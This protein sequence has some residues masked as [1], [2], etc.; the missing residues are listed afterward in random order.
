M[1]NEPTKTTQ[2]IIWVF[3]K[4]GI[5]GLVI[6]IY[7]IVHLYLAIRAIFLKGII[8]IPFKKLQQDETNIKFGAI[9]VI[10]IPLFVEIIKLMTWVQ[11]PLPIYFSV[12]WIIVAEIFYSVIV[13]EL[14]LRFKF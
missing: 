2:F 7:P 10:T 8:Y 12:I 9:S 6:I 3:K 1:K 5:M 14:T 4:I 13:T 11:V